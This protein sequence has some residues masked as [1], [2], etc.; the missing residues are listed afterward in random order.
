MTNPH[1]IKSVPGVIPKK[2]VPLLLHE[3]D[4]FF[5]FSQIMNLADILCDKL[6]VRIWAFR[7]KLILTYTEQI[8]F[9]ASFF[10]KI[11]IHF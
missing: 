11:N 5:S 7:T 10:L 1:P 8:C 2:P 3:V 6:V 4:I 9:L